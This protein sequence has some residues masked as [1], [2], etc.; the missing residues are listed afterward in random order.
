MAKGEK[1][2]VDPLVRHVDAHQLDELIAPGERD[3]EIAEFFHLR[4]IAVVVSRKRRDDDGGIDH[5]HE[6]GGESRGVV[7]DS[8]GVVFF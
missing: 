8:E 1:I 4:T 5:R 2:E 3:G 7:R 6:A